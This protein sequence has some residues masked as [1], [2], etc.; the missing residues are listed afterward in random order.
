MGL[1][2]ERLD[3][4]DFLPIFRVIFQDASRPLVELSYVLESHLRRHQL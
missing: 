2:A 4:F 1:G 3:S